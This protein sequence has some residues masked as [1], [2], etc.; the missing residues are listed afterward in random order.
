MKRELSI[1]EFMIR[2]E[3]IYLR[4]FGAN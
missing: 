3:K 2:I 1:E 4:L